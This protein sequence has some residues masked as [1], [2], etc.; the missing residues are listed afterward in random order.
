MPAAKK[1]E[2]VAELSE[3]LGRSTTVI[4]ADYRGLSV[5]DSTAMRR[6][7]REAGLAVEVIKNT[8]FRLAAE[9]AGK[10]DLGELAEGPTALIIGFDDPIAPVKAVAEYQ[11]TARNTF[12]ARKAYVEGQIFA[13]ASLTELAA[14]PPKETMLAELAGAL[15]SPITNLYYLLQATL[16]EFSG[17]L[18][19]RGAQLETAG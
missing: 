1:V 2:T 18:D 6:Q 13:G 3:L 16:Q 9:Q 11:R 10:A 14:L 4:A 17:L 8:L 19:S 12:A 5:A 7:F 15:A